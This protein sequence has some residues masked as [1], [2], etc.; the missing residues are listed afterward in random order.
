MG[1]NVNPKD[2]TPSWLVLVEVDIIKDVLQYKKNNLQH[3]KGKV[4]KLRSKKEDILGL[5]KWT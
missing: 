2:I 3:M 1:Q 5:F 4:E